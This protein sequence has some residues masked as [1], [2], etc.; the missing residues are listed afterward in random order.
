MKIQPGKSGILS[1]EF[2]SR[3]HGE[4]LAGSRIRQALIA[5]NDLQ[6]PEVQVGL[7]ANILSKSSFIG[8][9]AAD[10]PSPRR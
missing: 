3:A 2:D 6:Q 5:S 9:P 4:A 8:L 10:R 7:L 1:I